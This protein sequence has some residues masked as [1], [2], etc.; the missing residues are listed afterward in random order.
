MQTL[1]LSLAPSLFL[2]AVIASDFAA[3]LA[4]SEWKTHTH[5]NDDCD[6]RHVN[7]SFTLLFLS[8]Q[9]FGQKD[10]LAQRQP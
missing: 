3:L 1:L 5:V 4:V 2:Y 6:H 7:L 8:R 9:N 10:K